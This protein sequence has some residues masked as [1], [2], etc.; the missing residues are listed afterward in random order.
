MTNLF[1]RKNREHGDAILETGVLGASVELIGA[2]ARLRTHVLNATPEER[3]KSTD[4]LDN[5]FRDIGIYSMIALAMMELGNWTGQDVKEIEYG[6]QCC[7]SDSK[8]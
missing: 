4:A 6:E 3:I 7:T 1:V 8:D 2:I 5:I